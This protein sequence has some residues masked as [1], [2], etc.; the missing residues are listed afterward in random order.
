MGKRFNYRRKRSLSIFRHRAPV[1]LYGYYSRSINRNTSEGIMTKIDAIALA[2]IAMF[3]FTVT[4]TTLAINN[5]DQIAAETCGLS[6]G[7]ASRFV[8]C[9]DGPQ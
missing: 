9:T 4:T 2:V 1:A 6:M 3:T 8:Y 7:S 5:A